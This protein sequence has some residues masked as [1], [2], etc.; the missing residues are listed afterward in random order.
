MS[1]Q[2]TS[3]RLTL[4]HTVTDTGTQHLA[5]SLEASTTPRLSPLLI[6]NTGILHLSEAL[7]HNGNLTNLCLRNCKH[8]TDTGAVALSKMLLV[9]KSLRILD[10]YGTSVGKEGAVALMESL[11]HNQVLTQLR[12]P[13]EL[14]AYCKQ[15]ALYARVTRRIRL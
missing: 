14:K 7:K 4:Q 1:Q 5:T 6:S 10:L 15:L 8:I 11:L 3:Y 12:L 2:I 9:N 13:R